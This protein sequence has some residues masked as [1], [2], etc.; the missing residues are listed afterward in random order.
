L[1]GVAP[2]EPSYDRVNAKYKNS[3]AV[4]QETNDRFKQ[5]EKDKNVKIEWQKK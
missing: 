3:R 4:H 2:V 1:K 5:Y